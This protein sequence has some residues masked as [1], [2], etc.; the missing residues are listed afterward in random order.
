M[1]PIRGQS[2]RSKITR[3]KKFRQLHWIFT[4]HWQLILTNIQSYRHYPVLTKNKKE[5]CQELPI[6]VKF[7][8]IGYVFYRVGDWD[9]VQIDLRASLHVG[10]KIQFA[11]IIPV[12]LGFNGFATMVCP[13]GMP[14][15]PRWSADLVLT[16][17]QHHLGSLGK[18]RRVFV[19]HCTKNTLVVE[20]NVVEIHSTRQ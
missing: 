12:I 10:F 8:A 2:C 4:F 11:G 1:K 5:N 17:K 19:W 7:F 9:D 13:L 15:I 18:W 16:T 14:D 3:G 6:Q 20:M